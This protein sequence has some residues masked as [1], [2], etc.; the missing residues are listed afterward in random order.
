MQQ[1]QQQQQQKAVATAGN[2]K[3]LVCKRKT[4][5][6]NLKPGGWAADAPPGPATAVAAAGGQCGSTV[7]GNA[8]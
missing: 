4:V 5:F 2:G 3:L 6:K 8:S 1:Q 7:A